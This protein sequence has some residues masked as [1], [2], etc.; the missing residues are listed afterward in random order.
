MR[1][2]TESKSLRSWTGAAAGLA[3]A[4]LVLA[5]CNGNSDRKITTVTDNPSPAPAAGGAAAT[6]STPT[7]PTTPPRPQDPSC[8]A[9]FTF[10]LL[11]YSIGLQDP[12]EMGDKKGEAVKALQESS[13][14]ASN[15]VPSLAPALKITQETVVARL[16]GTPAPT[17]SKG[18]PSIE[19]AGQ[20]IG[21]W[22][23]DH[24]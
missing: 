23:K 17:P 4:V 7:E 24:C 14:A 1:S 16:Q 21:Q 9:V 10:Q 5:G 3:C 15:A 13:T 22:Q 12:N 6:P 20:Q 18:E 2:M 19:E 8:G 11:N